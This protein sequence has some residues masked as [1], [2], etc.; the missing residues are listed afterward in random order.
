MRFSSF[1]SS[2]LYAFS[3]AGTISASVVKR[4]NGFITAEGTQFK[5]NGK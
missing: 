3:A 2:A 5:L 4:N 1:F